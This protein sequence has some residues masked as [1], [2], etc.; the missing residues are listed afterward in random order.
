[1]KWLQAIRNKIPQHKYAIN[2]ALLGDSREL[3]WSN[4]G[5]WEDARSSYPEAC[6]NLADQLAQALTLNS[7]DKILDLACG[8]GASLIHWQN[9]YHIEQIHA[10][11]LQRACV[12]KIQNYFNHSVQI[13]CSSFLNLNVL[14]QL[15]KFDVVLC[16]D[17]AYHCEMNSFLKSVTSVLNSK[18]KIGFHHL[19]LS[20]K[21]QTL[22]FL[23]QQK[24]KLLLKSADVKLEDVL[25][26]IEIEKTLT[27]FDFKK[28]QITDMS[29]EVFLG[30]S[31]YVEQYL[32]LKSERSLDIFKIEMTAKLCRK[33]YADGFIRYVQITAEK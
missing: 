27:A 32:N 33:L 4:L 26:E 2:A 30:F 10:V 15:P 3:A 7:K 5:Y 17:A 14:G 21:F 29:A 28:I 11:E 16:I 6:A 12:D 24:Y 22:S 20:E 13:Y 23:D 18:G 8:Q 25:S 1:M 9:Q 31:N 19:M